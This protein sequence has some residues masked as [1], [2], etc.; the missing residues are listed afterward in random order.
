MTLS[1]SRMASAE[2]RSNDSAQSPAWSRN[3]LPSATAASWSVRARASPANTSG[4]SE[5]RC[6]RAR[7]SAPSSGHGGCWAAGRR[8]QEVGDQ[9]LVIV[10]HA[11]R[12]CARSAKQFAQSYDVVARSGGA[13][14]GQRLLAHRVDRPLDQPAGRLG[15]H[16][17]LLADL[18]VAALAAV[19]EA[20]ALLHGVAGPGV[21]HV[22]QAVQRLLLL[23]VDQHHLGRRDVRGQQVDQ[24]AAVVVAHGAVE[25]GGGGEAVEAGVL[26]VELLAV[27][28]GLAQRG[29]QRR[30]PV[31]GQAHEARLLVERPADRLADPEGGVGGELEAL[32]PVE[33]VD[34]VLEAEVA[35]L[36]EVQQLHRGREG[37]APGD[38]H[39][40]AEV[41]PDEAVLGG[42]GVGHGLA[43]VAPA[44]ARVEAL[45][46]LA[47][48][49]DR[50]R[51]LALLI[52]RQQGHEA[53]FVEIL[54][55][56]ITHDVLLNHLYRGGI[57]R[58]HGFSGF[59]GAKS[60]DA[61]FS[62]VHL[63]RW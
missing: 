12:P 63:T 51:Q 49:L 50:L 62:Y 59:S 31:A 6:L 40:E 58:S 19:G 32:A 18:A 52:C 55:D 3:A 44:L 13:G 23:A 26:V 39:D 16:A 34:G 56:R 22:E 35:L 8:R 33:L 9:L 30:R 54:S 47:P 46:G 48:T 10:T 4:G 60:P 24:L 1:L 38:A 43:E 36:D 57:P 20:E 53:D 14:S 25:G 5:P 28:R 45:A 41:G 21:E 27:A 61:A 17:Q 37:V 11:C 15:G 29:T 7:S 2:N 42:C